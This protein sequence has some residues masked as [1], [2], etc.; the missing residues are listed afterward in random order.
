[1]KNWGPR[2][3]FAYQVDDKT[4]FRGAFST[5]YSHGGG[6]GGAGGA[7]TGP[8]QL[9]FNSSPQLPRGNAGPGAGPAFYLNNSSYNAQLSNANFGGPGYTYPRRPRPA[10]LSLA[11]RT[12]ATLSP[13]PEPLSPRRRPGLR[14]S[15]PFG[16]RA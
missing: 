15:V 13:T 12:S 3:G 10:P 9:G 14:R 16:P 1:M 11:A 5:V 8:S 7:A 6:T 4:V 2:V